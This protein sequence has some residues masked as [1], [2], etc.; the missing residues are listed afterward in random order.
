MN[1]ETGGREYIGQCI[2]CRVPLYMKD[3]KVTPYSEH[4]RHQVKA[5]CEKCETDCTNNM[6]LRNATHLCSECQ[7]E[8]IEGRR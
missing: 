6:T 3:E 4:C 8:K 5:I 1:H 7:T 2:Y